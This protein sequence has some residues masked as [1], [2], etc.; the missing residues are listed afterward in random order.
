MRTI[1]IKLKL[2]SLPNL[3]FLVI[4]QRFF[5]GYKDFQPLAFSFIK[6]KKQFLRDF[7]VEDVFLQLRN[8]NGIL[9]P[10]FKI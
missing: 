9:T 6:E 10:F 1:V 2:N 5:T 8:E 4:T 7:D 3:D